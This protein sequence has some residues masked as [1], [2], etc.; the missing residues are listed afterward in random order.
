MGKNVCSHKCSLAS[1]H[2][3]NMS[4]LVRTVLGSTIFC[5][6]RDISLARPRLLASRRSRWLRLR[7]ETDQQMK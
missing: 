4:I 6:D 5:I 1:M 2:V 3:N 7:C